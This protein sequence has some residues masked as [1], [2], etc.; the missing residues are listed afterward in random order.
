[1][2]RSG[3]GRTDFN[4]KISETLKS[5]EFEFSS[6][7][8]H[9]QRCDFQQVLNLSATHFPHLLSGENPGLDCFILLVGGWGCCQCMV[10]DL[11]TH[12]LS[13]SVI[14]K[15]RILTLVH[16]LLREYSLIFFIFIFYLNGKLAVFAQRPGRNVI[17]ITYG[18]LL[19]EQNP[20]T[21]LFSGLNIFA[22]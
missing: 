4:Y 1:M 8:F 2:E 3:K 7:L 22:L 21:A 12:F 20:H 9:Y 6:C 14:P 10:T 19:T 17:Y 13:K 15:P 18:M 11:K 5:D 16:P